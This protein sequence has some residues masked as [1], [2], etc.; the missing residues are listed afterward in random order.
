MATEE[1]PIF[2]HRL[3]K[4]FVRLPKAALFVTNST[5]VP[6]MADFFSVQ[7][8]NGSFECLLDGWVKNVT[9]LFIWR[10]GA[11]RDELWS[12]IYLTLVIIVAAAP[13]LL[14]GSK[15]IVIQIT[16]VVALPAGFE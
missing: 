13:L 1:D 11:F 3:G 15:G 4:F 16:V 8:G 7:L 9:K 2:F 12:S 10:K 5:T 14:G 6:S